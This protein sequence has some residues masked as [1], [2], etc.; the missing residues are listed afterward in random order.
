MA[1][2]HYVAATYTL[3]CADCTRAPW[4]VERLLIYAIFH[5]YDEQWKNRTLRPC[6][7]LLDIARP[8][9]CLDF[10]GARKY[11]ICR[12][13]DFEKANERRGVGGSAVGTV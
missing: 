8:E 10:A 1:L 6:T 2:K 5:R 3:A 9:L 7:Q 13:L 11:P 4:S 12:N